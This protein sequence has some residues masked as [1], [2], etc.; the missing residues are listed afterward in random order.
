M[1][2]EE[3]EPVHEPETPAAEKKGGAP[4]VI[5][6]GDGRPAPVETARRPG[7]P[8]PDRPVREHP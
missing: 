3:A 4:R 1:T 8:P 2:R 6:L 5:E 7:H